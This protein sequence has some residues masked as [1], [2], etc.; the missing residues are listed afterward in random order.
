MINPKHKKLVFAFFMALMMSCLMSFVITIFNIGL[1]NGGI[2]LWLKA[3]CFAFVVAFPA[4]TLVAPIA[5]KL[6][7]HITKQTQS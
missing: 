1:H 3:W 5:N 7:L 2:L 4:I 6:T